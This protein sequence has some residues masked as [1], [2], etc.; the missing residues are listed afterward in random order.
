MA[1]VNGTGQGGK[2]FQDRVLAAEVRREALNN[3]KLVLKS[4]KKSAARIAK[5]SEYKKQI[6]LKLAGTV[7]PRLNE[8]TGDDGGPIKVDISD[9]L[10]KV[11]GSGA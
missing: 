9:P 11:Y 10:N 8:H 3:I 5:W 6:V 4:D 1:K 7:L 2:S